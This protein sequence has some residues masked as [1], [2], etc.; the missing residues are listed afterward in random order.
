MEVNPCRGHWA[1]CRCA[2]QAFAPM[3]VG[4]ISLCHRRASTG[5]PGRICGN[6]QQQN[7]CAWELGRGQS[8]QLGS[9]DVSTSSPLLDWAPLCVV[10]ERFMNDP[11]SAPEVCLM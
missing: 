9:T 8:R 10:L 3:L 5:W 11:R 7:I 2:Q 6:A 1:A 4:V